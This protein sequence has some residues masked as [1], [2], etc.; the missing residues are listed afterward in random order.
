LKA[1]NGDFKTAALVLYDRVATVEKHYAFLTASVG[2]D[3]MSE[4]LA[5]LH[6]SACSSWFTGVVCGANSPALPSWIKPWLGV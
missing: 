2:G 4:L 6:L 3:R 1:P 5:R